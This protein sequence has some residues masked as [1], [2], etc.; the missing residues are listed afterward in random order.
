MDHARITLNII[1]H[2][3]NEI[4]CDEAFYLEKVEEE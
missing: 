3:A 1:K 4:R 2:E